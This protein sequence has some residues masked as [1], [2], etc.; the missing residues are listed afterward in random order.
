MRDQRAPP[1]Q[2]GWRLACRDVLPYFDAHGPFRRQMRCLVSRRGPGSP[3]RVHLAGITAPPDRGVGGPAGPAPAAGSQ[4]VRRSLQL[5]PTASVISTAPSCR[6]SASARSGRKRPGSM[7][8]Q[9]HRAVPNRRPLASPLAEVSVAVRIPV[10]TVTVRW[11]A[12]VDFR[13]LGL[14]ARC[15]SGPMSVR[16]GSGA[17]RATARGATATDGAGGSG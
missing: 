6:A 1:G 16:P 12:G 9:P 7:P 5:P 17:M 2:P 11:R 14:F 3:W 10:Q 13:K 15:D 8:G 4:R